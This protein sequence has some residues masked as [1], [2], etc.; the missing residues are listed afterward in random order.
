[1][2][3][4]HI[5][6][7]WVFHLTLFIGFIL[8]LISLMLSAVPFVFPYKLTAQIVSIILI[9]FGTYTEGAISN[10][11]FWKLRVSEA[12]Q[13]AKEAEI[14]AANISAQV[15]YVYVDRIKKVTEVKYITKD[16]IIK[17]RAAID[18]ACKVDPEAI[19][20]LNTSAQGGVK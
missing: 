5:L 4:I 19:S 14:S 11:E 3:M 10:D 7:M 16:R 20:I 1:M 18:S 13:R 12:E 8:F 2:W 9:A 17:S 6:P 15:E